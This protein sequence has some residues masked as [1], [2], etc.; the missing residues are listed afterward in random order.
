MTAAVIHAPDVRPA[1]PPIRSPL[2]L[3]ELMTPVFFHRRLVIFAFLI[4][5]FMAVIV[6]AL[7]QPI[8]VAESRLLILLGDDYV[9]HSGAA[10]ANQSLSFDRAQIVQAEIQILSDRDLHA[11]ALKQVGLARVY[12]DIADSP[13]GMEL[14]LLRFDKDLAIE[15]VPQSNVVD[16]KLKNHAPAVAAETLNALIDLYI[17]RRREIFQQADP[18]KVQSEREALRARL[19]A[20]DDQ[21]S[22]FSAQHGFGDYD[23]A[24]AAAQTNQANLASQVQSLDQQY[25]TRRGRA[26]RLDDRLRAAPAAIEL[27]AD[28]ARSQQ[29]ESLTGN[30][31]TLQSQ[32]RDAA[33]KFADN[34][35]LIVDLDRRIAV[36]QEQIRAAPPKQVAN[37][38]LGVNPT[39]QVLDS[40]LADSQ[41]DMAGLAQGR[42]AAA[43]DLAGAN[44]RLKDLTIIG[45]EF[46]E[47]TR[48]RAV[49]EAAYGDLAK[50]AEDA[51][52]QDSLARAQANVKVIQR[53]TPP[54]QGK[55]GRFLLLGAGLVLG[56]VTAAAS[57]LFAA[58]FSE[59]MVTPR[60]AEQK[61]DTPVVLSVPWRS[62]S[63]AWGASG[64]RLRD[65]LLSL[66][67]ALLMLRLATSLSPKICPTIQLIATD[68]Q[69]GVSTL[70]MDLAL[71]AATQGA[72]KVLLID[73]EPPEGDSAIGRLEAA[74]ARLSGQPGQRILKVEGS[75][76]SVSRPIGTR[77]LRIDENQWDG[78]LRT[79]R[80]SY[81]MI[82]IDSPAMT[83]SKAGIVITPLVDLTLLV[84]DAQETRAAVARSLIEQVDAAGGQVLGSILNKRRFPIPQ[85]IYAR[86]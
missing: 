78:V 65:S 68:E 16:L 59:T 85:A 20:L 86:L 23:Q 64:R 47:M 60:D 42:V 32:R 40:E 5:L 15:N 2:T 14:A 21:I 84:I 56:L 77:D 57:V 80:Q 24:L 38:R 75:S 7:A 50:R 35:P 46:R 9:F 33:A 19:V 70:A 36:L 69:A 52:L 8:F 27:Y 61:L 39:H 30:L 18:V 49:I 34:Y 71:L 54:I 10:G 63:A 53:A 29:I 79:A 81:D 17:E 62:G 6:A 74:G 4:P 82:V 72:R 37:Q 13:R 55:A 58:A 31:L 44:A 48:N 22:S 83:R 73:V 66:D 76:L 11:A 45:P 1:R 51:R 41:G 3:R 12:P 25:A 28:Q 67:D 26:A 43:R